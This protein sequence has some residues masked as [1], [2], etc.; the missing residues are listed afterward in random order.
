[1]NREGA[2]HFKQRK[3]SVLGIGKGLTISSRERNQ[4]R[5][6]ADH[7]KQ[8]KE[9]VLG[10]GKGL[11]ISSRE[12]NQFHESGKGLSCISSGEK[13]QSY[14]SGKGSLFQAE[15]GTS[16]MNRE[17]GYYKLVCLI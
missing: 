15:S 8:R 11:T 1:M 5:D 13:N 6:R 9:S 12:R 4:N 17:K 16:P 14:E 2:Y 10:I 3:E 7:F